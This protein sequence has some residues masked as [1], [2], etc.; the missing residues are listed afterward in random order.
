MLF[1]TNSDE[2]KDYREKNNNCQFVYLR[3]RDLLTLKSY[4]D[5]DLFV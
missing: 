2:L 5:L 1:F 3:F 4:F